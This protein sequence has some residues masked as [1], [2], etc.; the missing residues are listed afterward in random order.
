MKNLV[1]I[2]FMGTGKSAVGRR[3]A[4]RLRRTFIDV[5]QQIVAREG[6]SIPEIFAQEGEAYFRDVES[7]VITAAAAEDG[8]VIATG[9]GAV[10]RAQNVQR[11]RANGALICLRADAETIAKRVSRRQ[12]RPLL[13]GEGDVQERIV[14]LLAR[15]TPAYAVADLTLDTT[16]RSAD[17]V[18]NDIVRYAR[19]LEP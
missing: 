13:A 18:A 3:V 10:L 2:G 9:G 8:A 7:A 5:D 6:R 4:R 17:A 15:R 1:L 11:L 14:E 19:R 16:G 12:S